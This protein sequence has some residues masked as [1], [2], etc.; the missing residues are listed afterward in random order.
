MT[1]AEEANPYRR[2]LALGDWHFAY[3]L[4]VSQREFEIS[5]ANQ[6]F[7]VAGGY[8]A[9]TDYA[10]ALARAKA[11]LDPLAAAGLNLAWGPPA[12]VFL[13]MVRQRRGVILLTHAASPT[14]IREGMLEFRGKMETF[15][16]IAG[17]V[18]SRFAGA[19]IIC[20]CECESMQALVKRRAPECAIKVADRKLNLNVWLAYYDTFLR[21]FIGAPTTFYDAIMRAESMLT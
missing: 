19:L 12:W 10:V 17:G 3:C 9:W 20:A 16:R 11:V 7:A 4:P 18:S 6:G 13:S 14:P 15:Q 2:P 1:N 21:L 5:A 8:N